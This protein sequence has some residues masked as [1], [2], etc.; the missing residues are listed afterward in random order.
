[1]LLTVGTSHFRQRGP[2]FGA[3]ARRMVRI[4]GD[5]A[6]I[7]RYPHRM[8]SVRVKKVPPEVHAEL[9]RRANR[10]GVSL[11]DYLLQLLIRETRRLPIDGILDG[12]VHGAGGRRNGPGLQDAV[13]AIHEGRL[14]SDA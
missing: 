11:Q 13:H 9:G 6:P 12:I 2:G 1:M 7:W 3:F 14:L 8:P 10:Q 4:V 5:V